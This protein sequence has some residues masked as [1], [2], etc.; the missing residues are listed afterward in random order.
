MRDAKRRM[1]LAVQWLQELADG[2]AELE[3][4]RRHIASASGDAEAAGESV[5]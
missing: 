5:C 1:D 4:A 2:E 3:D